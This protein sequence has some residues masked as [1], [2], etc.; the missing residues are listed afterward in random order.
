MSE[1]KN[2]LAQNRTDFAEDRTVLAHERS[3]ASWMRTGMA[4]VG[5]GIAF[6]ALFDAIEPRWVPRAIASIFLLIAM[7]VFLSAE[8]R[9]CRMLSNL[10]AH[11]VRA[12]QPVNLRV[13]AYSLMTAAAALLGA[14]WLLDW[15]A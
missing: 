1:D 13:I 5:I 9:A 11:E 14:V 10:N 8:R 4:A 15:S 3:F 7:F 6:N 2:E 12:A